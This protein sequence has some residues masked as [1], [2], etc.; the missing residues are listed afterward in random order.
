MAAQLRADTS[1]LLDRT[2][3]PRPN[4]TIQEPK[5]IKE[6]RTDQ[7][8]IILT[9]DKG[10]AMV[11][12]GRQ[13][14]NCKALELLYIKNTYK[15]ILKDP[16]PKHKSQLINLLKSCK[17]KEKITQ[18]TYKKLYPTCMLTPRFYGLPQIHKTG[19]PLKPIVSNRGSIT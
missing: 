13:D 9:A 1:K 2:H 4:I 10:T 7:S 11:V 6:L 12:M 15:P 8:R 16:T 18:D 17:T 19:T 14:C 3:I 5:A